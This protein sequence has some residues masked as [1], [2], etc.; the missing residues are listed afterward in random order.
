M[1]NLYALLIAVG[2]GFYYLFVA[3]V[4]VISALNFFDLA[5]RGD[6]DIAKVL[7]AIVIA[8]ALIA[9]KV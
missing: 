9:L 5:N 4:L 2:I 8:L 1:I 3:A 7:W 6:E